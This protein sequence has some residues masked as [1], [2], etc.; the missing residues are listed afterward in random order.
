M[1]TN[2]CQAVDCALPL[3]SLVGIWFGKGLEKAVLLQPEYY[4]C[5]SLRHV[6]HHCALHRAVAVGNIASPAWA[7]GLPFIFC[8]YCPYCQNLPRNALLPLGTCYWT[9]WG[10]YASNTLRS[11]TTQQGWKNE[12]CLCALSWRKPWRDSA[13]CGLRGQFSF[14]RKLWPKHGHHC[15]VK[16]MSLPEALAST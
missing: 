10:Q 15:F 2:G 3:P 13:T 7:A 12:S 9:P 1:L 14:P 4:L 11:L 6:S 8:S 16:K 5:I